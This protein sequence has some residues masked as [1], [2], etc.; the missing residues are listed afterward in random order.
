MD[1]DL[2]ALIEPLLPPWPKRSPGLKPIPD[3]LCLQ[4]ILYVLRQDIA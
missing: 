3:R 2:W 1:D 4:G